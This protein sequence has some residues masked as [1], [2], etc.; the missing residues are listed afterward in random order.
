MVVA[1]PGAGKG[2]IIAYLAVSTGKKGGRSL[3]AIHKRELVLQTADRAGKQFDFESGVGYYLSGVKKEEKPVMFGSIQTM[4]R[5]KIATNFNVIMVDECHRIKT[6]QYQNFIENLPPKCVFIGFTATPFRT[7]KKGFQEEFDALVQVTTYSKLV[8]DRFLVPTRVIAPR[9]RPDTEG[10]HLRGGEFIDKELVNLYNDSRV[11]RGVVDR[12]LKSGENRKTICFNTNSMEHSKNTAKAFRDAGVEAYAIDSKAS[13]QERTDVYNAFV[14]NEFKV[15]C[16]IGLFTEGVSIDDVQCIIFNVASNS[17]QKWVQ[18]ATRGSR[19][20]WNDDFSDWKK[21]P[22][23]T[24]LK[25]D[26]LI[27]DFGGNSDRHGPVDYY[28]MFGFTLDGTPPKL[29]EVNY[30]TCPS[31]DE[32]VIAHI[33]TC[34]QCGH[35]FP[36][37]EKKKQFADEVEWREQQKV[38]SLA[39]KIRDQVTKVGYSQMERGLAA[40][41]RPELLRTIQVVMGYGKGWPAMMAYKLG[42]IN[43]NPKRGKGGY[44]IINKFLVDAERATGFHETYQRAKS[45]YR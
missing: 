5:R 3:T 6:K 2:S 38:K 29:G 13:I 35:E 44:A 9:T 23:G 11:Y 24:Y 18:A 43:V 17:A 34:P 19:P 36:P 22:D 40:N 4:S 37:K 12:W 33:M 14:N 45:M 32:Q 21:T 31:C 8:K 15:L 27:L 39:K 16:N 1:P 20:V 28:D 10:L 7:D 30:K 25:E 41:P 26:C 42:Y